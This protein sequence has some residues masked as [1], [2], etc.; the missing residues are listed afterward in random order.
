MFQG[1]NVAAFSGVY[2]PNRDPI[3]L[4]SQPEAGPDHL[5]FELETTFA[6]FDQLYHQTPADQPET[7][8]VIRDFTSYGPGEGHCAQVI[9]QP[10]GQRHM[11][12][13]TR[14]NDQIAAMG[15]KIVNEIRDFSGIMLPIRIQ[16]Q[17]GCICAI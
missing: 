8:L 4:V 13:I 7:G 17:Y 3:Q 1:L 11:A 5:D 15:L 12:E 6:G 14:P 10:P 16:C 9:R 2:R